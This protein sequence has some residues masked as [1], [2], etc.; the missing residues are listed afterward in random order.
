MRAISC[1]LITLLVCGAA[2]LF[3]EEQD[4]T[5][6]PN[7]RRDLLKI[8]SKD[9]YY[10][11]LMDEVEQKYA[12]DSDTMQT[13]W[14]L[15]HITDSINL[16]KLD[17]IVKINGWPGF[18]NVGSDAAGAAFLVVQHSNIDAQRKY[19]PIIEAAA[20]KGEAAQS[21]VAML[22]DR[23][24]MHEG[25]PQIYGSQLRAN[26]AS[27]QMEFWQIE[28]EANVNKRRAEVGLIPLEDYAKY[29]GIEY[30]LPEQLKDE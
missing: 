10:R 21:D 28:D 16:V 14:S 23:I 19:F 7:A 17:R 13:L 5:R 2:L 20:A 11:Q 6:W 22:Q 4:R 29:F 25:K 8:G 27:G 3:A 18:S 24:L 9:Q 26:E 30:T 1:L 15:Q 12:W